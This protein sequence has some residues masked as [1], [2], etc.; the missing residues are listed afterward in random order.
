MAIDGGLRKLFKENLRCQF[1]P[2][3]TGAVVCGVPDAEYCFEGG[4]Q[5]WVEFK[6][7]RGNAVGLRPGQVAWIERRHAMGGLVFVAV[8]VKD[9]ILI[10]SGKDARMLKKEGL[11]GAEPAGR[12]PKPWDWAKISSI[13]KGF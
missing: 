1:T 3:E 5:G 9:D 8:R 2:I 6:V 10:F 13:L 12:F 7:A 4:I 11:K